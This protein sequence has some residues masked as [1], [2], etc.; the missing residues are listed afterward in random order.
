M[1]GNPRRLLAAAAVPA[2]VAAVLALAVPVGASTGPV[3]PIVHL[4][5]PNGIM[6]VPL[7]C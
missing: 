7:Q 1:L 6:Q 4:V 3:S 2:A 5:I